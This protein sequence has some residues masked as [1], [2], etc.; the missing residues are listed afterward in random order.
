MLLEVLSDFQ[1]SIPELGA[2]EATLAA[3]GAA[4]LEQLARADRGAQAP[5][6]LPV[7]RLP[8]RRAR[9]R[10]RAAARARAERGRGPQAGGGRPHGPRAGPE[11][12]A[13]D[14]R[15]D[16]LGARAAAAG[17]RRHRRG[18]AQEDDEHH[19]QA[20]HRPR[21]GGRARRREAGCDGLLGAPAKRADRPLR[22]HARAPRARPAWPRGCSSSPTSCARR[23]W[24]WDLRAARRLRGAAPGQLDLA[25][26]LPR[27]AGRHPGQVPG[28]PP[29]VRP[30]LRPLLLPRRR[31]RGGAP[32]GSTSEDRPYE[33]DR[34]PTG[35]TSRTLRERIRQAIRAGSRRRD[36]RPGPAGHRRVR[37]PGRGLGRDRR[38][39]AA[40][41]PHAR[42]ARPSA[43]PEQPDPD[44]V[45]R[46]RCAVRAP[47]AARARAPADRA[48][49]VPA[50]VPAAARVRPRA[51]HQ[52]RP[53]P[54]RG[55]P[56]GRPAQAAAGHPGPR[57]ARPQPQ[58]RRSTCGA[59]CAPRSRPAACRSSCS[60]RPKRPRRP[61]LYV[62]CDVSTSVTSASVF[63]LSVLHALHDSSASCARSCSSS[64]SPR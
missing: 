49:P 5:L 43:G 44:A 6:P 30:G 3:A 51:A 18:R 11:E 45:P 26:G 13:L 55:A 20:P 31:A 57:A 61:E 8:R 10:D 50:P 37:A 29:R 64:G 22:R 58:R 62:L 1:I 53:G 47:P 2:I 38:R 27:G 28:G 59:R 21:P 23:A 33:G 42:A 36:A 32:A 17:R 24:P 25:G 48:H 16:R 40:H 46:E 7:A 35:S 14:R 34:A 4:D 52:P 12:A 63:F 9:A 19:R 15:V 60:Y 41:P 54:G 56:R 39:R